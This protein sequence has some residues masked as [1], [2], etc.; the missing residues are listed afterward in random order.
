MAAFKDIHTALKLLMSI[1]MISYGLDRIP[2]YHV[3]A[4]L[5]LFL[6][7]RLLC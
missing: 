5:G 4:E 1:R 2:P 7:S 6:V 3:A